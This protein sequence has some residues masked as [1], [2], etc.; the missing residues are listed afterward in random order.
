MSIAYSRRISRVMLC[1][2]LRRNNAAERAPSGS[3]DTLNFILYRLRTRFS[4]RLFRRREPQSHCLCKKKSYPAGS[5]VEV[6]KYSQGKF[7]SREKKE[8]NCQSNAK[9]EGKIS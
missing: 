2:F 4:S 5:Y 8:I 7:Q 1:I 3:A 6:Q 9:K